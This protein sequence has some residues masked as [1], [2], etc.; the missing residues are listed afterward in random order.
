MNQIHRL[1]GSIEHDDVTIG[2]RDDQIVHIYFKPNCEI[3]SG[4]EE[5]IRLAIHRLVKPGQLLPVIFE[6]GEFVAIDPETRNNL[7]TSHLELPILCY[8][9]YVQNAA[10]RLLA[11]YYRKLTKPT[12]PFST[13]RDFQSGVEWCLKYSKEMV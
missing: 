2:L 8:A 13:F 9:V 6:A 5:R 12:R 4:T 1:L 7:K 3:N 10:Q 11:N